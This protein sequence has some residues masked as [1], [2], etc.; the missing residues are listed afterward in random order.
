MQDTHSRNKRW[1]LH[2]IYH[3]NGH[4]RPIVI[5]SSWSTDSSLTLRLFSNLSSI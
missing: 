1:I 5:L 4:S 3:E 2:Q